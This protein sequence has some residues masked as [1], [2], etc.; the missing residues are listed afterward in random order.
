VSSA[1][2]TDYLD[3]AHEITVVLFEPHPVTGNHITETGPAGSGFEFG[4]GREEFLPA[5][6][7]GVDP[8]FLVIIQIARKGPLC[9]FLPQDMILFRSEN[10]FPLIIGLL[11]FALCQ[12]Q[13]PF[14]H[15]TQLCRKIIILRI[16]EKIL[17]SPEGRTLCT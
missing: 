10:L 17:T 16:R 15:I 6:G 5:G 11:D 3:P 1:T 4:I 13:T 14:M 8:F 2:G 9:A 12:L 7:T